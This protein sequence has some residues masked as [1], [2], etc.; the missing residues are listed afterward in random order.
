MKFVVNRI[1]RKLRDNETFPMN[2]TTGAT[3]L[4]GTIVLLGV[5]IFAWNLTKT[6]TYERNLAAFETLSKDSEL[7]LTHRIE[8]YR[9]ALDSGAA[10]FTSSDG[11]V[12]SD[13]ETFVDILKIEE[14]LP[15]ISSKYCV[16]KKAHF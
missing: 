13:W 7:A 8:S 6:T 16:P 14:T 11:V 4:F 1:A 10:L 15:G 12:K 5:T 2:V 9:Q 3:L